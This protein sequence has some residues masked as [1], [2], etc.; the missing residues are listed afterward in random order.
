MSSLRVKQTGST[1]GPREGFQE[2]FLQIDIFFLDFARQ[3]SYRIEKS[4]IFTGADVESG[5]RRS[6]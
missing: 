3:P 5:M 6:S 2:V 4:E 1:W